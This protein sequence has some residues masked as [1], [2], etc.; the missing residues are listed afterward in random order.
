MAETIVEQIAALKKLSVSQ[1]R[2]KYAEVFEEA[3]KSKNKQWLFKRVAYRIQ[4]L[5]EGGISERAKKRAEELARDADLRLTPP[6]DAPIVVAAPP[7][8][9]P[10]RD[11]RL[12]PVGTELKRTFAE[13]EHLVLVGESGFTYSGK[14]YRSL[15]AI[16]K[17]ISGTSWNGYGFFGLLPAKEAK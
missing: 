3:S 13:K 15:S 17:E 10:V 8:A 16:A 11:P 9:A 2:E 7:P 1:L 4:E 5:A 14:E 12:P 6:K